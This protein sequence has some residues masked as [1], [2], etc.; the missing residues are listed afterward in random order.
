M[1]WHGM[2]AL[3]VMATGK[4]RV[5]DRDRTGGPTSVG[6]YVNETR[7]ASLR[8]VGDRY[9]SWAAARGVD[10]LVPPF[11]G[12]VYHRCEDRAHAEDLCDL[13]VGWGVP[14]TAIRVRGGSKVPESEG[15]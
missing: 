12:W 9:F 8:G 14:A 10:A 13:L 1:A 15:A 3:M 5:M 11:S 6:L 7:V 2:G 4:E